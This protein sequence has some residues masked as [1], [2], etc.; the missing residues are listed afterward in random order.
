MAKE[1]VTLYIDD[2][3]IRLLVAKGRQVKRWAE[4]PLQPGQVEGAV[5]IA[6]EDVAAQL[7]M[8]LAAQKITAKRVILGLSGLRSLTRPISLPQLPKSM[9]AE[10]VAREAKKVLPVPPEQL[11][12]SWR[13]IPSPRGRTRVFLAAVPRR[14]ADAAV[15]TLLRAGLK[16]GIMSIKPLALTSLVRE[17]TAIIVDVQPTE[18]DIVIM[19]E[20]L[21]QPVRTVPFPHQVLPWEEKLSMIVSDLDRTIKFYHS[22]NPERPLDSQVPLYLSGEITE[23]PELYQSLSEKLGYPVS[24]LASPLEATP[25]FEPSRYLVNIG[26]ALQERSLAKM[27]G[28]SLA[29]SNLLPVVYRPK[30]VSWGKV[31]AL[32]SAVAIAGLLIPLTVVISNTSADIAITSDQLNIANQLLVERRLEKQEMKADIAELETRLAQVETE[33]DAFSG[34]LGALE[35]QGRDINSYLQATMDYKPQFVELTRIICSTETLTISGRSPSETEVLLY[36]SA[37]DNSGLFSRTTIG[38]MKRSD[39]G[40][41]TFTLVLNKGA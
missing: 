38:S 9:V 17:N 26:L 4:V 31:V 23:Q 34:A 30:P 20:G 19:V 7:R 12:I 15:R 25:W 18:F 2:T 29:N 41:M 24:L 8:L 10:A 16:P 14:G 33:L 37:L 36:A 13:A 6:E 1:L 32:P 35:A 28:P 3:S 22:N 5:I 21:P 27:A 40:G 39:G 11:Y